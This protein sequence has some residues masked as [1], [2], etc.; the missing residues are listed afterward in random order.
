MRYF[1][2]EIAHNKKKFYILKAQKMQKTLF[3]DVLGQK[4][5]CK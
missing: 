2:V 1:V 5:Y 4:L 3:Q